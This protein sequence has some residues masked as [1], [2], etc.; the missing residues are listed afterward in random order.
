MSTATMILLIAFATLA[1]LIA[2]VLTM[3]RGGEFNKKYGNK[4]MIA[5][6]V[7]QALAIALV[8]LLFLLK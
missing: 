2:G 8:G 5:R 3:V 6:V 7:L 1:V 4:L